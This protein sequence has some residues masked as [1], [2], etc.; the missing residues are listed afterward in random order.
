M[1]ANALLRERL[2]LYSGGAGLAAGSS[3][4]GMG[5][6]P[7]DDALGLPAEDLERALAMVRSGGAEDGGEG[8]LGP[9]R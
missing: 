3:G 8:L 2:A 6:A 5:D 9:L 1:R 7:P 4:G